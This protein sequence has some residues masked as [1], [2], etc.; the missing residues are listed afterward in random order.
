MTVLRTNEESTIWRKSHR[1]A[2]VRDAISPSGL[3]E[4]RRQRG[5][6]NRTNRSEKKRGQS[7]TY[8]RPPISPHKKKP[9]LFPYSSFVNL[10]QAVAPNFPFSNVRTS[11]GC[12]KRLI[13]K[14]SYL[15]NISVSTLA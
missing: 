5:R 13:K 12:S 9:F 3:G 7:D 11:S 4:T 8:K 14:S 10:Q 15:A 1:R 2:I 6:L